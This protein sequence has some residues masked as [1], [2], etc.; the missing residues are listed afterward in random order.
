MESLVYSQ[1]VTLCLCVSACRPCTLCACVWL[2]FRT[3]QDRSL[4]IDASLTRLLKRCLALP[5][6][7]LARRCAADL[8]AR[9]LRP[10]EADPT[11]A[12]VLHT[13]LHS[14][15]LRLL[16]MI[17]GAASVWYLDGYLRVLS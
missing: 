8:R 9:A 17:C 3:L 16:Q 5:F 4:A 15:Y 1:H 10:D 11:A 6:A 12:Q 2:I 7:E 13:A 14:L